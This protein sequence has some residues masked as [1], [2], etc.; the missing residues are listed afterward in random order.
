MT[1]QKNN[2]PFLQAV[3]DQTNSLITVKDSNGK[4]LFVNRKFE[5][6]VNL[7]PE[8]ISGATDADI[9]PEEL[10][11]ALQKHDR[12]VI[13]TAA[14]LEVEEEFFFKGKKQVFLSLKTPLYHNG[15]TSSEEV[16][17][18]CTVSVN[19]TTRKKA[20]KKA[21]ETTSDL[22][23][24]VKLRTRF[25]VTTN[26]K[27]LKEVQ[28][29]KE[30]EAQFHISKI[31]AE[32]ANKAKTSFLANMSHEIRTPLN[33][34]VLFA[35]ALKNESAAI[36]APESF[37]QFIENIIQSGESLSQL[38][39]NILDLSKIESG[40]EPLNEEEV[41]LHLLLTHI[42]KI[43]KSHALNKGVLFTHHLSDNLPRKIVT[44]RNKLNKIV[45]NL[46]HNAIKFTPEGKPVTLT[47]SCRDDALLFC[48]KD[49]GCGIA[50]KDKA[51][52]FEPFR[53]LHHNEEKNKGTG[54]GLSITKESV[55][56]LKGSIRFESTEGKGT[57]FF[58]TLPLK[59]TGDLKGD[60]ENLSAEELTEAFQKKKVLLVEDDPLSREALQSM[61]SRSGLNVH[62]AEDGKEG[63]RKSRELLPDIILMDMRMKKM[64]GIQATEAI[65]KEETTAHIPI[66]AVSADALL[67]QQEE[68]FKAGVCDYLTKPVK[69][70]LLL[71]TLLK[72]LQRV[73]KEGV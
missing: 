32:N 54:L 37:T 18:V 44:D 6:L 49:E 73:R 1:S 21:H 11:K 30:I 57:H 39:N 26:E 56:L 51:H 23:S 53:Q 62:T 8:D 58:V 66:I 52:I 36:N 67:N 34:I 70:P 38:I 64:N 41:D 3:S 29:R 17:G 13:K 60:N 28:K 4:Y 61:L 22:E 10:A 45:M 48:I 31:L 25:L 55:E 5:Q 9:F 19:I 50:E 69:F 7:P 47:A 16:C 24:K 12:T 46:V 71:Q 72:H 2:N 14:P 63:V 68:A 43:N 42:A 20:E 15:E 65:L 35:Q 27:L 40:K 33:A 59:Q